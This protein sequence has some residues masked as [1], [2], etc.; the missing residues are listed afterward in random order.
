MNFKSR[1]ALAEHFKELEEDGWVTKDWLFEDIDGK[2]HG[3]KVFKI[4]F[5]RVGK[6]Y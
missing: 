2:T 1:T 4:N 5:E 3:V 6:N